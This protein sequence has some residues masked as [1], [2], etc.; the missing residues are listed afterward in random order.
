MQTYLVCDS[1]FLMAFR[2]QL[3]AFALHLAFPFRLCVPPFVRFFFFALRVRVRVRFSFDFASCGAPQRKASALAGRP[4]RYTNIDPTLD[5]GQ[6][7][8]DAGIVYFKESTTV[9]TSL[10]AR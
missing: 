5:K 9:R 7:F 8:M 6:T 3:P 1:S 10:A 2:S 4:L